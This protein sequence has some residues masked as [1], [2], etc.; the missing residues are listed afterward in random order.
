MNEELIEWLKS[1]HFYE[2]KR[3]GKSRKSKSCCLCG[4]TLPAGTA[5]N[6]MNCYGEDG[7]YPTYWLCTNCEVEYQSLIAE[8]TAYNK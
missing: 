3:V 5:Q 7:K 2:W 8:I 1:L 6:G 4:V